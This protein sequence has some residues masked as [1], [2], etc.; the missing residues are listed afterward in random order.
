MVDRIVVGSKL[1]K[2]DVTSWERTEVIVSTGRVRVEMM[3]VGSKLVMIDVCRSEITEVMVSAGRVRV[4]KIVVGW[5]LVMRDS[6]TEVTVSTGAG[7]ERVEV[8][9]NG[10]SVTSCIIVLNWILETVEKIVLAS[11][12]KVVV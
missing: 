4:D 5:K 11:A 8:I 12:S 10:G 9:V 2:I 7:T 1:V 3:V 6:R